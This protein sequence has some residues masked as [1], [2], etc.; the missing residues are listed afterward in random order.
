METEPREVLYYKKEDG[1]VPFLKWLYS[2]EDKVTKA[3]IRIR[4]DRVAAGDLGDYRPVG[5]G[6]NE[7]R[8]NYGPGYRI[9]FGFD[10]REIIVI[11]CGGD[12]SSQGK[13]IKSAKEYWADYKEEDH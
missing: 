6:V 5:D 3:K 7:L 8:L 4:L 1:A 2:I 9:Y 13:D 10:G 12:K 11:L